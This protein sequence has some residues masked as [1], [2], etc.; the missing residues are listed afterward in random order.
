MRSIEK[1]L[2][3]GV[4]A[5][6][7]IVPLTAL[8]ESSSAT[9][10]GNMSASARLNLRVTIPAF[11]YFQVGTVGAT[12][13]QILFAP[14]QNEVGSGTP[15]SGSGGDAAGGSGANVVVRS[16]SGQIT[17]T[18][19]NDA[20]IG[21]LGSG[22]AISLSEISV[23][24]DNGALG[25]PTLSDTGGNTSSPTPNNGSVTDRTAVWTYTY[26]NNT[27]PASGTYDAQITY[28]AA[29]F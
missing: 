25:A 11:L 9:G 13:D 18:E 24:S 14:T 16:N 20:G 23:T 1:L 7:G 21:G 17:I 15:I 2:V 27:T 29:N 28:T 19:S 4:V 5:A 6:L 22:G 12:V 3:S 26:D 8:A 10:G